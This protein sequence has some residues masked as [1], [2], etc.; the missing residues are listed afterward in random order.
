MKNIIL[1]FIIT[2]FMLHQA[3]GDALSSEITDVDVLQRIVE[4]HREFSPGLSVSYKREI[5]TRSMALL[6]DEMK[7]DIASGVFYFRQPNL[8]KVHQELPEEEF[9]IY[10]NQYMWWYIPGKKVAHRY[11]GEQLGKEMTILC[12]IFMGLKNPDHNF[13]IT[14]TLETDSKDYLINLTPKSEWEE[15]DHIDIMVSSEKFKIQKI[16]LYNMIG[17]ITRFILGEFKAR[18]DIE[19]DYFDFTAPEGIEVVLE[20]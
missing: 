7:S 6:G 5:I 20:Q 2:I 9:I 10:N 18:S 16:E 11:S 13:N 3:N 14:V 4:N 17:S 19:D 1:L 12:D 8:L 15:I